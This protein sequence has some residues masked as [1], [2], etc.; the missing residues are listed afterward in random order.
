MVK[1]L[2]WSRLKNKP[3]NCFATQN[4][5][6]IFSLLI[7]T[8]FPLL[9][10]FLFIPFLGFYNDDWLFSYIGHF[11][12]PQGLIDGFAGDRPIVGYLFALN[13]ILLNNNI[14]LWHIYMFLI[15]L[16][17]GY[18]L[19]FLLKKLMSNR[20]SLITSITL[21]FL[22]YPGFLQQTVPLGYQNYITAL[23]IWIASLFFTVLSINSRSKIIFALFT[24]IALTLQV[25]SF[26]LLEF[27]IGM[28]ILR[29]LLVFYSAKPVVG[30][31]FAELKK[32][33][34]Y[35]SPYVISLILF[36]SW[37][38]F[39]FKSA[40]EA[41]SFSWIIQTYYSDPVWIAKIPLKMLYS[42][43]STLILA[44]FIP[45]I[46]KLSRL[47][48]ENSIISFSIGIISSTL[49]YF[50]FRIIQ[51]S[52][53]DKRLKDTIDTKRLG[54]NLLFIGPISILGA[55][56]P[57]IISGRFISVFSYND[58]YDRYTIS[59]ILGV[60]FLF[61]GFLSFK[62][63]PRIRNWIM[64]S[65][66]AVS[67]TTHF[68]NGY[69]Y[70]LYWNT[71]K[72]L[73]WQ[74]YWRTPKI[75]KNALLLFDIPKGTDNIKSQDTTSSLYRTL[76]IE[77]YQIWAPGNLFFNYYNPRDNY[78]SGQYLS[79]EDIAQ[80]IRNKTVDI[81]SQESSTIKY[82]KDFNN[83]VIIFLPNDDS[84]LWV[85]DKERHELPN[86][87][88]DL[89]RTNIGYSNVDKLV[90]KDSYTT[91][92][93]QIFGF[94]P[95]HNW[96]YYFQK[97]SLARQLKNWSKLSQ[98]TSEVLGKNLKPKDVNEWLPFIEGLI[99]AKKYSQAEDLIKIAISNKKGSKIFETNICDMLNR[100]KT[101]EL[102]Y[103]CR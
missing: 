73:W 90:E 6:V 17:G 87:S 85:L 72:D 48:L 91:P 25:I 55:L 75:Q 66:V 26:L 27:F 89:L 92:P 53:Y 70:K 88:S 102:E 21:L 80:K 96:C 86:N 36:I 29:L 18:I 63:T 10:Y 84:C 4:N 74:L 23:T 77:D 52:Q 82:K 49:L 68:M 40:R 81:I 47:P 59:S 60:G 30:V 9:A 35:W 45:I 42:F 7:I 37:R 28:E 95:L 43:L 14:Y 51:K 79:T 99:I 20:L 16:L 22:I 69:W 98:L 71:Q 39:L 32:K 46:V 12:G 93:S 15:R 94:E 100:L 2:I 38:I 44:Y 78:F 67:V 97:A 62:T 31:N 8:I 33:I 64:I 56:I 11:Y 19:F 34:K 58:N 83:T 24:L 13:N 65:L 101:T 76:R 1:F 3:L 57:I 50:Y 54:K 61:I 5:P 41:T 103:N